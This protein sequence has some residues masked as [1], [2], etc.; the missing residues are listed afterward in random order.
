VPKIVL[1]EHLATDYISFITDTGY[2][3][4]K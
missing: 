1:S 2:P 4:L 3:V